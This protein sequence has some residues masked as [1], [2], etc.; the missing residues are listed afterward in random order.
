MA[1]R[2]WD[3]S[4]SVDHKGTLACAN[5]ALGSIKALRVPGD[6][7]SYTAWF[8]YATNCSPSQNDMVNR[9][10]AQ[11]G[12]IS[13][14]EIEK[15]YGYASAVALTE[16]VDE[17]VGGVADKVSQALAAIEAA[18]G[19]IASYRTH[20][21]AIAD[22]LARVEDP[23]RLRA[24]VD[25]LIR[26]TRSVE[27]RNE[28]F[29]A[30]LSAARQG[31]DE[32]RDDVEDLRGSALTDTLTR[33]ANRKGFESELDRCIS[34]AGASKSDLCLLL[35]DIDRL[36]SVNDNFGHM[37]GDQVIRAVSH[38]L[39]QHVQPHDVPAR[40]G[41]EEFAVILP[42]IP[43]RSALTVAEQIRRRVSAMQFTKRSTGERMGR[44]TVSG[45]VARF[46]PGETPW[47]LMQR[48][49][50]CLTAAKRHGRNRVICDG[51]ALVA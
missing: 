19:T 21:T 25:G 1:L 30:S 26:A 7:R 42:D 37:A 32:L 47:T 13:A 4:A 49:D 31:V 24:I 14:A 35:L 22:E 39:K 33:L 6:P 17:L 18:S 20:L 46:R 10:V 51:D 9:T 16:Q 28:T 15:I 5:I 2:E 27:A 43:L 29:A 48:A 3:V 23:D 36:G 12:T 45:G 41:G 40:V 44:V 50:H 8:T 34:G 38:S 11:T